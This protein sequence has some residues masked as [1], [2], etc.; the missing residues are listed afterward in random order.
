ML[1]FAHRKL[2]CVLST[3]T[4]YTNTTNDPPL[5]P[6]PDR[7]RPCYHRN[8][9]GRLLGRLRHHPHLH[10]VLDIVVAGCPVAWVFQ[11]TARRRKVEHRSRVR[12]ALRRRLGNRLAP[13]PP[14]RRKLP[15]SRTLSPSA[16]TIVGPKPWLKINAAS[17]APNALIPDITLS[18]STSTAAPCWSSR[19][20]RLSRRRTSLLKLYLRCLSINTVKV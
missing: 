7:P 8:I 2:S 9:C 12:R 16:R 15:P 17:V 14:A 1:A 4:I 5:R 11:A 3:C 13:P 18:G 10:F 19:C 20:R 6:Q